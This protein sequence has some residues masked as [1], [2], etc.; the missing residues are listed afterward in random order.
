MFTPLFNSERFQ[1]EYARFKDAA[2]NISDISKKKTVL[3][4]IDQLASAVKLI[5]SHYQDEVLTRR[6]SGD[7]QSLRDN[8][9]KLRQKI[10]AEI[11]S[12]Q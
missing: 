9:Q 2:S 6:D 10:T 12:Q 1:N 5:D 3:S 8:I 7:I 11:S 4:L